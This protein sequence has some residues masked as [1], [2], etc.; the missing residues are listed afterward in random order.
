M[1]ILTF[2]LFICPSLLTAQSDLQKLVDSLKYIA[3]MPYLCETGTGEGCGDRL[4][5]KVVQ[6]KEAAI[7]LLIACLSDATATTATVPNFGGQW[8]VGDIAYSALSEIIRDIPT[9]DLL[10]V[11]FDTRDCGY[12][13]Y[14]NHLRKRPRNRRQFKAAVSKWYASNKTSLVWV[15]SDEFLTCD[16]SGKHPNEGHFELKK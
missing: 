12:C 14:W 6:Q 3:D 15:A 13:A 1:K 4:F 7:P 8:A 9:F 11:P 2:L 10:G 5:W 16:C